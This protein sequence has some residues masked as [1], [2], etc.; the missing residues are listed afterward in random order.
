MKNP[1][2]YSLLFVAL[3]ASCGGCK[4]DTEP[5]TPAQTT[6]CLIATQ[7]TKELVSPSQTST[8]DPE[9]VTINGESFKV[10]TTKKSAYTYDK[11][12][13]I[14]TE[15]N[16]Y[17]GNKADS[18]LYQYAPTAVTIRTVNLAVTPK[19]SSTAIVALNSQGYAEKQPTSN[20]A[21]YDKDGYLVSLKDN[22]YGS[23]AKI[24]NG[25][26]IELL[27]VD[28]PA[29]SNFIIKNEY[30]LSKPGL[31]SV[32]TF[33]GKASRNLQTQSIIDEDNHYYITPNVY[34]TTYLYAFDNNDRIKRQLLRG[35]DGEHPFLYGGDLV[36]VNDFTYICP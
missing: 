15:Y 21:K 22:Y 28:S 4:K 7:T 20:I 25:N 23:S 6:N 16:T 14:L 9:T 34:K 18:V 27:F 1:L 11:Q 8:L 10:T 33:Y 17:P 5:A 26:V 29:T 2:T 3:L 12:G 32:Q 36:R 31:L 19:T 24:D 30:D 13:R 35:K